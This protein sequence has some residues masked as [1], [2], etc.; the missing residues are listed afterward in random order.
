MFTSP[1]QNIS[2]DFTINYLSCPFSQHPLSHCQ[3]RSSSALPGAE[4]F[5]WVSR[6]P[7]FKVVLHVVVRTHVL[8]RKISF[9]GFLCPWDNA[10]FH[11]KI[12]PFP[13]FMFLL[14]KCYLGRKLLF[15]FFLSFSLTQFSKR[16]GKSISECW[17]LSSL[18]YLPSHGQ[19]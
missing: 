7:P 6:L 16:K 17:G 14:K 18:V 8:K 5:S 2:I 9:S 12:F 11:W 3:F 19:H 4:V 1:K 15:V 10:L 13:F